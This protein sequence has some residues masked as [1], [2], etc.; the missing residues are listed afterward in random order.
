MTKIVNVPQEIVNKVQRHDVE[1]CSRRDIITFILSKNIDIPDNI[2]VIK[3]DNRVSS[4]LV[5]HIRLMEDLGTE[6]FLAVSNL[7]KLEHVG[8][9]KRLNV[10]LLSSGE[11]KFVTR[12]LNPSSIAWNN[13]VIDVGNLCDLVAINEIDDELLVV[14][15]NSEGVLRLVL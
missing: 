7:S 9:V 2:L 3:V 5:K 12:D 1:M 11:D 10:V 6:S 14:H 13:K 4:S 8:A 15:D